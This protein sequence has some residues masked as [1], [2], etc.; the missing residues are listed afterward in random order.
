MFEIENK[1][2]DNKLQLLGKL[3]ASLI[4]EIR[5]PLSA[6]KLNIDFL[7]LISDTLP[8][9]AVESIEV[10]RDALSRIQYLID[11]ILT[12][13]RINIKEQE[14]CSLNEISRTAIDLIR[15][16]AMKKNIQLNL[17]LDENLPLGYFD[18]NK[19]LQVFIN[20]MTNAVDS[21]DEKGT[22]S[23]RTCASNPDYIIW[24]V[25]DN[26]AGIS[27]D[28]KEKI[29]QDFFTSKDEGT[30]LGLS[31]CEMILRQYQAEIDFTSTVGVGTK[32]LIKFNPNLMRNEDE[33]QNINSR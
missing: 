4:H 2:Q 29:F 20:L 31:V 30:G 28:V 25:E 9:E 8:E 16:S 26:G 1:I 19:I 13:T 7:T 23:V 32:F 14:V 22:V 21:C 17:E 18:K 15:S 6:I 5:N 11:N 33:I 24:E 12:F 10:S 27:E 3:T